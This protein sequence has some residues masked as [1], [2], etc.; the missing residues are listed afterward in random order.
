MAVGG[1]QTGKDQIRLE[2]H[3]LRSLSIRLQLP[4]LQAFKKTGDWPLASRPA[5]VLKMAASA[6]TAFISQSW[7]TPLHLLERKNAP[8]QWQQEI[9][10]AS[11]ELAIASGSDSLL[12]NRPASHSALE[13]IVI[14]I[15]HQ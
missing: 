8:Q 14:K 2:I 15:T 4:S 9:T 3:L 1:F 6:L 10:A 13:S 12:V 5:G 7:L 11:F